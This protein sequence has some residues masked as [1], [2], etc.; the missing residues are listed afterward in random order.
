MN[1]TPPASDSVQPAPAPQER[2]V[3]VPRSAP[4]VTYAIIG[5]T[6]LVFVLQ[7]LSIAV[8]GRLS[9]GIDLLETYGALIGSAVRAGE[10]WRLITPILLHDNSFPLHI[11]FNMYALYSF[12]T[13][14]ERHFGHRRFLL[15]YLLG[16]FSGNVMS[17]VVSSQHY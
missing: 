13:G 8:F 4:Y 15:L 3:A 6:S 9:G 16:G 12:G 10:L 14:L 17:F 1:D 5:V 7:L 2:R 11:L